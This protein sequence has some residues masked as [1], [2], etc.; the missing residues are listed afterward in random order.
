M[1]VWRAFLL[2][3][4]EGITVP[5]W[6][7]EYLDRAGE[8]LVRLFINPPV[9]AGAET[10]KALELHRMGPSAFRSFQSNK[11]P[12]HYV[13]AVFDYVE[14]GTKLSEVIAYVARDKHVSEATVRRAWRAYCQ[15]VS[16][17]VTVKA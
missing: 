13:Y 2:A 17:T 4:E 16:E 14:K 1:F 10:L 8:Q 3:R 9:D 5:D 7:L 15:S 11:R 6:V 12:L